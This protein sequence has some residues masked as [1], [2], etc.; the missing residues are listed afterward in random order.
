MRKGFNII[1]QQV[2]S[3]VISVI[4]KSLDRVD[5]YIPLTPSII[6][7]TLDEYFS[8]LK[9]SKKAIIKFLSPNVIS[10]KIVQL[11]TPPIP[12]IIEHVNI[13]NLDSL[14]IIANYIITVEA[15][16]ENTVP[17]L[18]L[19]RNERERKMLEILLKILDST[20]LNVNILTFDEFIQIYHTNLYNPLFSPLARIGVK[21]RKVIEWGQRKIE[22]K[23]RKIIKFFK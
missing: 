18:I 14:V 16:Y 3:P 10:S 7:I 22:G 8:L 19:V 4:V 15:F 6:S 23:L 2:S 1:L 17:Y 20:D 11:Q 13:N 21:L 12:A 5:V 9:L